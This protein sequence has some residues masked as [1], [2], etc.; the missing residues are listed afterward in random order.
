MPSQFSL[1]FEPWKNLKEMDP[2][3]RGR[4]SVDDLSDHNLERPIVKRLLLEI[5]I[6]T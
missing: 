5:G 1:N 6:F 4:E 3:A 2:L